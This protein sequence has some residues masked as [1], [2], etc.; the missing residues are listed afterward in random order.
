M[1]RDRP[2]GETYRAAGLENFWLGKHGG[3]RG[4]GRGGG[5]KDGGSNRGMCAQKSSPSYELFLI[6]VG[7]LQQLHGR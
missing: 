6:L 4:G 2:K 1:C 7:N 5:A 3:G